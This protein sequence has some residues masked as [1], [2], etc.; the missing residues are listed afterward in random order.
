[1][2]TLKNTKLQPNRKLISFDVK[3]LY[4]NVPVNEAIEMAATKLFDGE[5]NE[6]RE[7][8]EVDKETFI[9]LAKLDCTD[10]VFSS[11]SGYF[12][13][14]EGLAM[15]IQPAPMLANIWMSAFE[16]TVKEDAL[17]FARYVDDIL[18]DVEE[19]KIGERLININILHEKL[20]FTLERPVNN[21]IPFLDMKIQKLDD[22]NLQTMWYR[23]PTGT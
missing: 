14:K 8:M 11:P 5:N 2:K 15:G 19:N 1:M 9:A 20:E 4:T 21:S 13:Q 16:E 17:I 18:L 12:R 22:G 3:S 10:V 23:K 7:K 6:N